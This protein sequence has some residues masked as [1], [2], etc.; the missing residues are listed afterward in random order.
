MSNIVLNELS[1]AIGDDNNS[2]NNDSGSRRVESEQKFANLRSPQEVGSLLLTR[3]LT[4]SSK[5]VPRRTKSF[6][7]YKISRSLNFD[8]GTLRSDVA[9][10]SPN[11][12]SDSGSY[13]EDRYLSRSAKIMRALNFTNKPS[14][15]TT[16]MKKALSFDS[17]SSPRKSLFVNIDGLKSFSPNLDASVASEIRDI[18]SDEQSALDSLS[19]EMLVASSE[20]IDENQNQTPS[21]Q[22]TKNVHSL[23]CATPVMRT[24][25]TIHDLSM[26]APS[27]RIGL[28]ERID[29]LVRITT[30]LEQL[31]LQCK[32]HNGSTNNV[33]VATPRN[34][35]RDFCED[36]DGGR[37]STPE[38]TTCAIPESM[39]AIKKSHR[40][41]RLQRRN[42]YCTADSSKVAAKCPS[43]GTPKLSKSLAACQAQASRIE[44]KC[45]S[46]TRS[47][48]FIDQ[49]CVKSNEEKEM[50]EFST[51]VDLIDME[52]S[53]DRA[54][55]QE[56]AL[57]IGCEEFPPSLKVLNSSGESKGEDDGGV[58][59]AIDADLPKLREPI[60]EAEESYGSLE[61]HN[62]PT[63]V[64]IDSRPTTPEQSASEGGNSER[65]VTPENRINFLQ[66]IL[67]DSI[68]KS[69]KKVK[70]E[71]KK[72]HLV[73]GAMHGR[74]MRDDEI[75]GERAYDE[76]KS[77]FPRHKAV[78]ETDR[79]NSEKT[80][81]ASTP[82]NLNSSRLL[83]SQFSS[84]KKS[85]K[86]D[87]HNKIIGEFIRRQKHFNKDRP[88]TKEGRCAR[89][90]GNLVT[91]RYESDGEDPEAGTRDDKSVEVVAEKEEIRRGNKA[92][93]QKEGIG[94][95]GRY[96]SRCIWA[97]DL[98]PSKRKQT[99]DVEL[100]GYCQGLKA[101]GNEEFRIF[102]PIKKRK[103]LCAQN[104]AEY[105]SS[106]RER[107]ARENESAERNINLSR[108]STPLILNCDEECAHG[109]TQTSPASFRAANDLNNGADIEEAP[110]GRLA[111][112]PDS[113]SPAQSGKST[114]ENA[115]PPKMCL[116]SASIKKSHRKNKRQNGSQEQ[117][118]SDFDVAAPPTNRRKMREKTR[119][120]ED[121]EIVSPIRSRSELR[122]DSGEIERDRPH[123]R[124]FCRDIAESSNG[125]GLL[126]RSAEDTN[127][128]DDESPNRTPPNDLRAECYVRELQ[129]ASIKRSHKKVRDQRKTL[130]VDEDDRVPSDD[131]SIFGEQEGALSEE[132]IGHGRQTGSG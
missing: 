20:S 88:S 76:N 50:L 94:D 10:N 87:K 112:M 127:E 99:K 13:D 77:E 86:K 102:T 45:R 56:S 116:G 34:L 54:T 40:K 114:P 8:I 39:S 111:V 9:Y 124:L 122:E 108:C 36:E 18:S 31:P 5:S 97:N 118:I 92:T 15:C 7:R 91:S 71:N 85:H 61:E 82:E 72:S 27:L 25:R 106:R 126:D 6:V 78:A 70:H 109:H 90:V 130:I 66:Q 121:E 89:D 48:N 132:S 74:Q 104:E 117:P 120:R 42:E 29:D 47:L 75:S 107:P 57:D 115:S 105:S 46:P 113:D 131:G 73:S 81:R 100:Q 52:S 38:N 103:P 14:Y 24:N 68:K 2:S 1:L 37:P 51:D 62:N 41:E 67:R 33:A 64:E 58:S 11:S 17:R 3:R 69:H 22:G 28:K 101:I 35:Y 123:T 63:A 4:S 129:R 53:T 44:Y 26:I 83:L 65:I 84:V 119:I 21:R 125:Q 49:L 128:E 93:V 79:T 16:K 59:N 30:P 98:S 110:C 32:S 60:G 12:S 43:L 95:S 96:T 80:D 23:S 19:G 55:D